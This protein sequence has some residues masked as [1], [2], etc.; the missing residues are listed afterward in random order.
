MSSTLEQALK[1]AP[2]WAKTFSEDDVGDILFIDEDKEEVCWFTE[3]CGL[4]EPWYMTKE[5]EYLLENESPLPKELSD[6]HLHMWYDDKIEY[7]VKYSEDK[8]AVSLGF[9]FDTGEICLSKEDII[10]LS[11]YA[12]VC[13]EDL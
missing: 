10:K 11:K 7:A 3:E 2:W 6:I 9:R 1:V 8:G 5:F 13:K 4:E 12:G